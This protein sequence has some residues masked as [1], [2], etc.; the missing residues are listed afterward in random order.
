VRI[1]GARRVEFP[2]ATRRYFFRDAKVSTVIRVGEVPG[3]NPGAPTKEAPQMRGFL[4]VRLVSRLG[5]E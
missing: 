2:P 3:S 1:C 4:L 5:R